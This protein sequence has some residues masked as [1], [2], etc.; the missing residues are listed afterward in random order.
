M[1]RIGRVCRNGRVSRVGRGSR[2]AR[3]IRANRGEGRGH[4]AKLI[5]GNS[6][7]HTR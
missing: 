7:L 3:V 6:N 1:S 5:S 2:V 4:V